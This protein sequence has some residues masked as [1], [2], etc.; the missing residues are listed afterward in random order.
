MN[1][2]IVQDLLPLYAEGMV[3]PA[4]RALVEEHLKDCPDCRQALEELKTALPEG[5]QAALPLKKVSRGLKKQ[6]LRTGL[7]ALFLALALATAALSALA[8]SRYAPA[9]YQEGLFTIREISVATLLEG[10]IT[11]D[12]LNILAEAGILERVTAAQLGDVPSEPALDS[13]FER[14][15]DAALDSSQAL[16]EALIKRLN[17]QD[18]P[19]PDTLLEITYPQGYG[20]SLSS[21]GDPVSAEQSIQSFDL[22]LYSFPFQQPGGRG[23]SKMVSAVEKGKKAAVYYLEPDREDRLV[24]GPDPIPGGGR[25]TL[26]RLAL[27][28]YLLLSLV[29]AALLGLALVILRK[30]EKARRVL[31]ILIG[32]P[33]AWAAG[34]LMI[35]GL[36]GASWE[37]LRD[38][39][40][41]LITACFLYAAWVVYWFTKSNRTQKY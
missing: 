12:T 18:E 11:Q 13:I 33:L 24:Y 36:T 40:Y 14:Q 15:A 27:N 38:L 4:S 5:E 28:Y 37:M 6:R 35:K 31:T 21:L 39:V 29:L 8:A 16:R 1:C 30:K 32:L 2:D 19:L 34:H 7:L 3:S 22:Q 26:P 20:A 41:I 10:E 25:Y 17:A 23:E 9:P